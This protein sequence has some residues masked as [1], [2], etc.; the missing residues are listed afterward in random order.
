MVSQTFMIRE[1]SSVSDP[2]GHFSHSS[3]PSWVGFLLLERGRRYL[4][5][6]PR[7]GLGLSKLLNISFEVLEKQQTIPLS[8]ALLEFRTC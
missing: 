1:Q 7:Y 5:G 3:H 8:L 6:T 2:A 4:Q